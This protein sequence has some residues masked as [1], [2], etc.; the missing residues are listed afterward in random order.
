[1]K[2]VQAPDAQ[3]SGSF[4]SWGKSG[5]FGGRGHPGPT[6]SAAVLLLLLAAAVGGAR[7]SDGSGVALQIVEPN[8]L[9]AGTTA[10]IEVVVRVRRGQEQAMLLTPSAEGEA[11]RVVRGRLLRRDATRAEDGSLHFAVPVLARVA[12]TAVLRVEL[13]TYDCSSADGCHAIRQSQRM[14]LEIRGG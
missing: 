13:L 10:A 11:L 2:T 5:R 12:G 9:R 4:P 6:A 1:M 3:K 14:T 8:E 7:A